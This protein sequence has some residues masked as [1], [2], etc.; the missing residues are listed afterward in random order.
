MYAQE[1]IYSFDLGSIIT[2]KMELTFKL[3]IL[4]CCYEGGIVEYNA[5]IR[6]YLKF[7]FGGEVI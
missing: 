5:I 2:I 3:L 7:A 1:G 6:S 4:F